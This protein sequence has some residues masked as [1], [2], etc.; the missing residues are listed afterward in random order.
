MKEGKL[1]D[2]RRKVQNVAATILP[3]EFLSA[4]YSLAVI[5]Y[6]PNLKNHNGTNYIIAQNQN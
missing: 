3:K 4:V 2:L 1:K 5:G 6:K